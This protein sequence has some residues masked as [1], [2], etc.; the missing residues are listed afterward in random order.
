M[1][2]IYI[3]IPYCRLACHYCNFHFSTSLQSIPEY[4]LAL[5]QEILLRPVGDITDW[6]SVYLGGGT[7][8]VLAVSQLEHLFAFLYKNKKITSAQEVTLE[9][10][11]EDVSSE[12]MHSLRQHTPVSRISL[13]VQSLQDAHLHWMNRNH[14]AHQ[15][16][17]SIEIIRRAGFEN[18][19]VDLIFGYQ[20]LENTTWQSDLDTLL[21]M[22][23]PHLSHYGLTI[24]P[25][26]YFA[27][28]ESKGQDIIDE[29][30]MPEQMVLLYR[31]LEA[32]GYRNYELSN[33][34]KPGWE[35]V[36]NSGY[37]QGRP[38]IGYGASAHGY[39]GSRTRYQNIENTP[40]YIKSLSQGQLPQE[41][42]RLSE[43]DCY[44]E[45]LMLHLRTDRGL[46]WKEYVA[47]FGEDSKQ[48]LLQKFAQFDL[49]WYQTDEQ[50][51]QL[52]YSGWVW[53]DFIFRA[54]FD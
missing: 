3:H 11:P 26:T 53:S 22:Q 1:A 39:D 54:L 9:M 33:S 16:I 42:E 4:L 36:H 51:L 17:D 6:S 2:G 25:K 44:H 12:Y 50:G 38:Y 21:Q 19:S 13:G 29:Q 47:K 32:A 27:H 48:D 37:W 43:L 23:V 10:N 30:Q 24:E 31:Q 18:I 14:N 8:S 5:E 28:L 46:V 34:A 41:V 7:P 52:T 49:Q 35:A 45:Y 20:R 40:L 15:A